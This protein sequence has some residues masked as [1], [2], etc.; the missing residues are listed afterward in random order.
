MRVRTHLLSMPWAHPERPSIQ[1][2]C[3]KGHLDRVLQRPGDCYAYSAF[4]SILHDV[5]GRTFRDFFRV[6]EFYGEHAYQALYLHRFGPPELRGRWAIERLLAALRA[7]RETPLSLPA[8]EG[9]A[10]ATR[11]FL[12]RDVGPNLIARGLNLVGFT[13]NYRQ[14]YSSLYAAE[15]L[16]RRFPE[17]SFLFVYGGGSVSLPNVYRVLTELGV[18]GVVV[19]GEGERKLELLVRTFR[20]LPRSRARTALHDVAGLDPGIIVIGE[21]VDLTVRDPAHHALQMES[22]DDLARPD[23][24]DYFAVLRRACADEAT[25]RAFCADSEVLVEGSRGCTARCDFCALNRSWSGYRKRS[26][27]RVARDTLALSRK[28]GTSRIMFVDSLCDAWAADYARRLVQAGIHQRS[29][30]ELRAS[31]PESFWTLLALGGVRSVQVGVE[32]LSAPLLKAIGKGTSVMQN[33][34][35]QKYLA[36]LAIWP[37]NHLITHHPASTLADVRETRRILDLI[38]HWGPFLPS[39]F[40]LMA[41]SPLYDGLSREERASLEPIRSFRLPPG[42][43]RFAVEYSFQLPKSLR[44]APDVARAW[45]AFE[46]RYRRRRARHEVENPRLDVVRVGPDALRVADTRDGKLLF[47]DLSGA[48]ARIYD[49]CHRPLRVEAIVEITGLSPRT[50]EAHLARLVRSRLVLRVGDVHLSLAMRLRDELVQR[51]LAS[52]VGAWPR[53]QLPTEPETNGRATRGMPAPV[54]AL[55]R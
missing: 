8:L 46:R 33:L 34:A 17:H 10:R 38:P 54:E 29:F 21:P 14:L 5:K 26:A 40:M 35:T 3:L 31:H 45:S 43:A 48:A 4:L 55:A 47:H 25:Y 52:E 39:R 6:G 7:A 18:P 51:F 16:R 11:R 27:D 49:G 22:L 30:M 19:V 23:Y 37:N 53:P 1:L 42:A 32:S 2:G 12:D 9:L 44:L 36:E 50:V 28:Y 15:H 20:G 24:D 41:G 13:V